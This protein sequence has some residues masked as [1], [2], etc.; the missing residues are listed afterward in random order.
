MAETNTAKAS[1]NRSGVEDLQHDL[2][3]LKKAI[4]SLA[5]DVGDIAADAT[6]QA[7]NGAAA[8]AAEIGERVAKLGADVRGRGEQATHATQSYIRD[9]P[10]QSVLIAFGAGV[11]ISRLTAR[12]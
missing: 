10:I 11:L 12:R 1:G 6:G 4:Q 2:D 3:D 9:N 7:K 8:K 5:K